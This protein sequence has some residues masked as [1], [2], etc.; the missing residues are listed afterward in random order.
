M[1][2]MHTDQQNLIAALAGAMPIGET[3]G[4]HC[5]VVEALA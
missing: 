5:H 2:E 1:R 4:G 3:V